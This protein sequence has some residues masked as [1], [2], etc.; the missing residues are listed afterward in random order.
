MKDETLAGLVRGIVSEFGDGDA[1][2]L[3]DRGRALL[4]RF[5]KRNAIFAATIQQDGR[6]NIPQAEREKLN[7]EG[8]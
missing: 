6:I 5:L 2:A 1:L 4:E 7:L 3:Q 8:G